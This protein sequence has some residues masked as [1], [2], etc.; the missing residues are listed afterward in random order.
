M[1][2]YDPEQ[3]LWMVAVAFMGMLGSTAR[4][5][6]DLGIRDEPFSFV[7]WSFGCITGGIVAV[8]VGFICTYCEIPESLTYGIV[9]MAAIATRELIDIVPTLFLKYLEKGK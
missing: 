1:K 4:Y 3:L 2:P 8:I 5:L 6:H 7:R 9:G